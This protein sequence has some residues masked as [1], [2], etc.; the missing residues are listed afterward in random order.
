MRFGMLR[1]S[2][3]RRRYAKQYVQSSTTDLVD[4]PLFCESIE[5]LAH[6]QQSNCNICSINFKE[7]VARAVSPNLKRSH[8]PQAFKDIFLAAALSQWFNNKD[9]IVNQ[10]GRRIHRSQSRVG[11]HLLTIGFLSIVATI[12]CGESTQSSLENQ[13]LGVRRW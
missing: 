10:R 6:L 5:T 12:V 8:I 13:G 11:W 7:E 4:A 9:T 1:L 3:P 2:L